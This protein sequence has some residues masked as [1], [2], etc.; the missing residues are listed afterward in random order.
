MLIIIEKKVTNPFLAFSHS[1]SLMA[2]NQQK[3][4]T[5]K[6]SWELLH[7]DLKKNF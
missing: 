5:L 1:K 3:L 7:L 4:K 2:W 6:Q